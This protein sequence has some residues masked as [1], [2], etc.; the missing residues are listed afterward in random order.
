M[1]GSA[2][3]E[4]V[5]TLLGDDYAQTILKAASVEPMSARE[6]SEVCD[7]ARSTVYRRVDDLV[8]AGM[9]VEHTRIQPDG[10]HHHVYE[11]RLDELTLRI[12]DGEFEIELEIKRDA[13]ERFTRMWEDIREV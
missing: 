4:E 12:A 3:P 11:T 13:T 2:D 10:S 5:F 8:E 7:S 1:D 6:L 9:L